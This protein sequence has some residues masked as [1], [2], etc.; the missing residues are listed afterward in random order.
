MQVLRDLL[1]YASQPDKA[2]IRQEHDLG[3]M[4]G[5]AFRFNSVPPTPEMELYRTLKPLR[6]RRMEHS[7]LAASDQ[8]SQDLDIAVEVT[9]NTELASLVVAAANFEVSAVHLSLDV[10]NLGE[11]TGA[12]ASSISTA[13][14]QVRVLDANSYRLVAPPASAVPTVVTLAPQSATVVL[15]PLANVSRTGELHPSKLRSVALVASLAEVVAMD[16]H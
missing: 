6:G 10:E 3:A 15:I 5:G 13:T 16:C 12:G 1:A 7:L 9:H 11:W 8:G 14:W 2:I 4:A